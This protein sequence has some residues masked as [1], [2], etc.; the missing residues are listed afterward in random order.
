VYAG[1]EHAEKTKQARIPIP[2][3]PCGIHSPAP[4]GHEADLDALK[5]RVKTL[6][7]EN[8]IL[9]RQLSQR[10]AQLS[11]AEARAEIQPVEIQV[12]DAQYAADLAAERGKTDKAIAEYIALL[13]KFAQSARASCGGGA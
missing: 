10:D 2:E 5:A 8:D 7:G 3:Q 11:A 4:S 6:E 12:P 9:R 1:P 13:A